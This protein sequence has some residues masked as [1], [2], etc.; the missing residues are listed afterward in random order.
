LNF[1]DMKRKRERKKDGE[2]LKVRKEDVSGM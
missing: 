1:D 2:R